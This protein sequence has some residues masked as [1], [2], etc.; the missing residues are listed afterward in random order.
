MGA[1]GQTARV[2][3][4]WLVH[5]HKESFSPFVVYVLFS[6]YNFTFQ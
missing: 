2:S 1:A 5:I 3:I 4:K 6:T